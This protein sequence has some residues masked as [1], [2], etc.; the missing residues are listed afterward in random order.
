MTAEFCR[1]RYQGTYPG[2]HI[3]MT[4]Y[5]YTVLYTKSPQCMYHMTIVKWP[6]EVTPAYS[7]LICFLSICTMS[8]VATPP[9]S[10]FTLWLHCFETS[11]FVKKTIN[12]EFMLEP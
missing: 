5:L 6:L 10:I 1:G 12:N 11:L 9:N 2:G 8:T 3:A 4:I 7:L